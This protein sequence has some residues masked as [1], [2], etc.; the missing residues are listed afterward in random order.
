[1][2]T[3][4]SSGNAISLR[5]RKISVG[6]ERAPRRV[7]PLLGRWIVL[8]LM[9]GSLTACGDRAVNLYSGLSESEA[10]RLVAYLDTQGVSTHKVSERD[11]LSVTVASSKLARASQLA[12]QAGLP[13]TEYK[14]FGAVFPKDGLISSPLEERARLTYATS[15]ELEAMLA[16]I[17]GVLGA[18]VNVVIPE[19]RNGRNTELPAAAVLIRHRAEMETD[20]LEMKVRRL[21]AASV[22][23]LVDSDSRQISVTFMPVYTSRVG[24]AAATEPSPS[25]TPTRAQTSTK[26]VP[27]IAAG[28]ALSPAEAALMPIMSSVESPVGVRS[29]AV[30]LI[31][32]VFGVLAALAVI[33]F[34][35]KEQLA[36]MFRSKVQLTKRD[37]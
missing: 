4:R 27:V 21:V 8:S 14:G 17:D 13:R 35:L 26:T 37:A 33:G 1:M 15:Q 19:R 25:A 18:R 30:T 5:D 10:N 22:P 29:R 3:T 12:T 9:L 7:T 31:G 20:L 32:I 36:D 34:M 11:G 16:D 24:V 28:Y 23:G 6:R 2:S